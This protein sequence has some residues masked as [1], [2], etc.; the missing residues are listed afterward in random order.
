MSTTLNPQPKP[1]N[2]QRD[3]Q[4]DPLAPPPAGAAVYPRLKYRAIPEHPGFAYIKVNSAE[5]EAALS[6]PNNPAN[7][8]APPPPGGTQ[9]PLSADRPPRTPPD[10]MLKTPQPGDSPAIPEGVFQWFDTPAEA[11]LARAQAHRPYE[12]YGRQIDVPIGIS[13]PLAPQFISRMQIAAADAAAAAQPAAETKYPMLKYQAIDEAP[14][15]KYVKMTSADDESALAGSG[16]GVWYDTPA[17]AIANGPAPVKPGQGQRPAQTG[18][19]S[20]TGP[21][22]PEGTGGPAVPQTHG[23]AGKDAKPADPPQ[24]DASKEGKDA[25]PDPPLLKKNGGKH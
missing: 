25:K 7:Q 18:A 13:A 6:D 4:R 22:A 8:A 10:G 21:A 19:D 14:G 24:G 5:E 12:E 11:Q 20:A 23:D 17:E 16:S 1:S 15:F 9:P 2:P 3:P